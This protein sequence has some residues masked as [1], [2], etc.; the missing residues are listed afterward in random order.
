MKKCYLEKC[1]EDMRLGKA[2][3]HQS[4]ECGNASIEDGGAHA[5]QTVDSLIFSTTF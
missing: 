2:Q 4:Q 3:K 5:D 1:N